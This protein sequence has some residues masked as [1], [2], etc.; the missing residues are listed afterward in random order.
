MI[1]PLRDKKDYNI[2]RKTACG[3]R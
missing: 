1:P 3:R 2:C